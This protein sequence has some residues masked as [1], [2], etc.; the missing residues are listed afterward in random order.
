MYW[1]L[2][3]HN[4]FCFRFHLIHYTN[5]G[6]PV[7]EGAAQPDFPDFAFTLPA[8]DTL[9]AR[10]LNENPATIVGNTLFG[11][12]PLTQALNVMFYVSTGT[13]KRYRVKGHLFLEKWSKKSNATYI[14]CKTHYSYSVWSNPIRRSLTALQIARSRFLVSSPCLFF[15]FN[16]A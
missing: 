13:F 1:H 16:S 7:A 6:Y 10:I 11:I 4:S 12:V 14:F 8:D 5:V 15:L 2:H 9:A 3:G